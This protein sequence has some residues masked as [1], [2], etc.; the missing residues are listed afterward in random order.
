MRLIGVMLVLA[1]AAA[2]PAVGPP[3][4]AAWRVATARYVRPAKGTFVLESHVTEVT[5]R[6]GVSYT[7]LTDRGTEKMTLTIRFDD[8][9]RVRDAAAVRQAGAGRQAVTVAFGPKGATLTRQGKAEHLDIAPDVVVT[10]AP[11]WSDIFQVIRRYDRRKGGKQSFAGLWVH[12]TQATR[13]LDFTV[14]PEQEEVIEAAGR[15]L[16]LRR[17]RVVL[18]SGAYLVWADGLG[19]VYRLMPPGRPAAAVILEGYEKSTARLGDGR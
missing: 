19:R 2:A 8:K 10:T 1:L 14:E 11:D 12:P 6:A 7:S 18:R 3:P 16:A 13:R 9:G 17:F 5:T 4:R 15:K